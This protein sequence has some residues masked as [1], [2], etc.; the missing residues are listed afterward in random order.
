MGFNENPKKRNNVICSMYTIEP[1]PKAVHAEL[2]KS[3]VLR[4][5]QFLDHPR[6]SDRSQARTY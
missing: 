4:L 5:T 3:G 6:T 1:H 2:E